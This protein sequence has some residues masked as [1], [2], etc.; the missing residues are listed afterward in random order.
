MFTFRE[1]MR[2]AHYKTLAFLVILV[3]LCKWLFQ[4]ISPLSPDGSGPA[5]VMVFAMVHLTWAR[6]RLWLNG[7]GLPHAA[8]RL[9]TPQQEAYWRGTYKL[10]RWALALDLL[11]FL[12]GMTFIYYVTQGLP[13]AETFTLTWPVAGLVIRDV[14]LF[15]LLP[16]VVYELLL[17]RKRWQVRRRHPAF[18]HVGRNNQVASLRS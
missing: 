6:G 18:L 3:V 8:P 17:A 7:W 14:G 12:A 5:V 10:S 4:N 11:Y 13:S 16:M 9:L 2:H 1:Y 15:M